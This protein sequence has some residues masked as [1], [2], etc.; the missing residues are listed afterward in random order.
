MEKLQLESKS[1]N[2][3]IKDMFREMILS[4]SLSKEKE[5]KAL[6]LR[7][8]AVKVT[9]TKDK[10]TLEEVNQKLEEMGFTTLKKTWKPEEDHTH[11]FDVWG[12]ELGCELCIF[13]FKENR[14][15]DRALMVSIINSDNEELQ[16]FADSLL[17]KQLSHHR[18]EGDSDD[19]YSYLSIHFMYGDERVRVLSPV[20]FLFNPNMYETIE[21]DFEGGVVDDIVL[22]NSEEKL[23]T[24]LQKF[25]NI[26][27]LEAKAIMYGVNWH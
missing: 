18:T 21:Q 3:L 1:G 8:C 10:K 4:L 15:R 9:R 23:V 25:C 13:V 22:G 7:E 2:V 16:E 24:L 19:F 11:A 27:T 6:S 5:Q 14:L 17:E 26:S 20:F 12:D